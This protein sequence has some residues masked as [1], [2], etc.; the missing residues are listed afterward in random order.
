[1][2][3]GTATRAPAGDW[4]AATAARFGADQK[5]HMPGAVVLIE[6]TRGQANRLCGRLVIIDK[7]DLGAARFAINHTRA[8]G[9]AYDDLLVERA[10]DRAVRHFVDQQSGCSEDTAFGAA[11]ILAV[12][13]EA[14]IT[15]REFQ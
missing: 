3:K 1:M 2:A 4:A 15:L 11:D 13:K 8:G 14:I 7:L 6:D 9:N 10:A 5:R 12:D